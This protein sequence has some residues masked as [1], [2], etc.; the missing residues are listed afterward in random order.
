MQ[1]GGPVWHA[2]GASSFGPDAAW[3]IAE[4][5]L[6]GVG[7][8]ELGEWREAGAVVR[9]SRVVHLR[10]RLSPAEQERVGGVRD[11]RGTP[12]LD[13]RARALL[14]DAPHLEHVIATLGGIL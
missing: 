7:S 12:E 2:S 6:A 5:A 14:R 13:E 11:V 8:A 9:G 10:R 1:L 4:G 3:R